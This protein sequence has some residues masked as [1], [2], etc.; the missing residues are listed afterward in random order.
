MANE[1]YQMQQAMKNGGMSEL[2][3]ALDTYSQKP[4]VLKIMK[5][6]NEDDRR[7][8]KSYERFWRDIEIAR[9]LQ[10]P[11]I[12]RIFVYGE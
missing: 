12:L 10:D 2:W 4:V 3:L 11:H 8:R 7:N 1:R 6:I 9:S 5:E